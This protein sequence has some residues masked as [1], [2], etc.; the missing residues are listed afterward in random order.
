MVFHINIVSS[1]LWPYPHQD[2]ALSDGKKVLWRHFTCFIM[3][4]FIGHMILTDLYEDRPVQKRYPDD[5]NMPM[6]CNN[7]SE[8]CDTKIEISMM[9][10]IMSYLWNVY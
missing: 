7:Y 2:A 3:Y 8:D 10:L 1:Y 5:Y 9:V 4:V 6:Y